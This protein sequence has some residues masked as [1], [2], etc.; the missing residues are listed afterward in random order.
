[1]STEGTNAPVLVAD[2]SRSKSSATF[3]PTKLTQLRCICLRVTVWTGIVILKIYYEYKPN[4]TSYWRI[5]RQAI[6]R[7]HV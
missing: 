6:N 3:V 4:R 2:L 1:M 7:F 5:R